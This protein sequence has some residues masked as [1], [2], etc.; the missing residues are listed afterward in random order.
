LSSLRGDGRDDIFDDR[1]IDQKM[2][3]KPFFSDV[4]QLVGLNLTR[5]PINFGS[6]E[7][8]LGTR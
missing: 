8:R 1:R 6:I 2:L 7:A 4:L 3:A 5:G